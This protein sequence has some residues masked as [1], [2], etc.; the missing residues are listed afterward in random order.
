MTP[1]NLKSDASRSC[2]AVV[3][4]A[5]ATALG[6][7]GCVNFDLEE[8][9]TD[10]RVLGVRMEPAEILFSPFFLFPADQRPP[11]PLPSVDVDVEVYAFDPRGG[12]SVVM[13]TQ[14]C[15]D[16]GA[17]SSCRLYDKDFDDNFARLTGTARTEVAALLEP[18]VELVSISEDTTP[19]GR[20]LPAKKRYTITPGA[21]DFFQ[22]KN[23][24]GENV[25][26]I[27]PVLPRIAVELENQSQKEAG[28]EVFKERS[29]KRLPLSMDLADPNLPREFLAD[30]SA[31]LGLTLCEGPVPGPDEV[32]DE[33]FEGRADCYAPRGPNSNP[34]LKGFRLETVA[35]ED[36]LTEGTLEGEP[37]LGLG[38]LVRASP[39]GTIALTPMWEAGAVERYQVISF[40]IDT[41]ELIVL[42]RVEDM[43]C[44]WYT[45]R[46]FIS[47]GTTSLTFTND[48]LGSIWQLPTDAVA[49]ERDSLVLVVLDQRGGTTVAEVTVEYR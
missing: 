9:V 35:T 49:G 13:S 2:L 41:S 7:V 27:F 17:D 6:A 26:S 37:D 36:E 10:T 32:A 12:D 3:V 42:N 15:P 47:S 24:A 30:L 43:A 48:R 29:F 20:V 34:A 45:T 18:E 31:G 19:V 22:P 8:Q 4:A 33:D 14:W 40:D 46:G 21:I 28:A 16:D 23:G 5:A 38:S 39:G 11:I 44:T 25:P 1:T